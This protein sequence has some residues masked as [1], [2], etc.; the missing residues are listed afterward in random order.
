MRTRNITVAVSIEAHHKARLWAAEFDVSLSAILSALLEQLPTNPNAARIAS[1][2]R[3]SVP[4]EAII[5][6]GPTKA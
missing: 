1:H 4:F 5:P 3:S 2:M 6:A